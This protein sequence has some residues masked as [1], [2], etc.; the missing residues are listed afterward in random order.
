MKNLAP[1]VFLIVLL[2]GCST[3]ATYK[4]NLPVGPAKPAGY[5][6]PVYT[7]HQRVPRPCQ[8]IGTVSIGGGQFTMFGGSVE[9]E[10]VKVMRIAWE[11]GA[12]AVQIASV[13]EPGFLNSSFRLT[14]NLLRYAD[15]WETVSVTPA[16][17]AAYLHANQQHLDPIEGVW[18]GFDVAPIRI[19]IMRNSAEPGRDFVGF[20]LNSENPV[21]REGYKKI[22]IRRGAQPGS[23]IFD[24]YLDNFSQQETT[25]ILSQNMTFS[26]MIQTPDE[27]PDFINY[28][29]IQ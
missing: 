9:S 21:W 1:F 11:K 29:K 27:K 17:F 24:Y 12:D 25:V 6:V 14:A 23:Y 20:I 5:P 18:E 26:L 7:E 2:T 28:A 4:P 3:M 10:M 16:Q 15:T 8:I 19:G 13:E 22:D